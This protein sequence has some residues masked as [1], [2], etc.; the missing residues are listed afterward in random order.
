MMVLM[1]V[2]TTF[3]TCPL[4]EMVYPRRLIREERIITEQQIA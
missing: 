3:M 2:I 1:A 4:L